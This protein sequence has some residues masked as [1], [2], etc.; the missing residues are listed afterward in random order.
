MSEH[1]TL[2]LFQTK[3]FIDHCLTKGLVGI[4]VMET[5][6]DVYTTWQEHQ[7]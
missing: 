2:V 5:V 6:G 7:C 4:G 1:D 3:N